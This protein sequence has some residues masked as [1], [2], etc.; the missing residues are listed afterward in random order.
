MQESLAGGA[1]A[2]GDERKNIAQYDADYGHGG[3]NREAVSQGAL[4]Q[5]PGGEQLVIRKG[6][7]AAARLEAG[8]QHLDERVDDEHAQGGENNDYQHE[9]EWV[10]CQTFQ[11]FH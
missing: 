2:G 9:Q 3:A 10:S 11:L 8:Q 7:V 5:A 4:V 1:Q 6:E